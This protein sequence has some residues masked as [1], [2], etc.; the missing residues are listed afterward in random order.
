MRWLSLHAEMAALAHLP[1][2][3]CRDA[4]ASAVSLMPVTAA[5]RP[6][7]SFPL[8]AILP[9]YPCAR[10]HLAILIPKQPTSSSSHSPFPLFFHLRTEAKPEP[11]AAASS[12][13]SPSFAPAKPNRL[14]PGRLHLPA[15]MLEQLLALSELLPAGNR[16]SRGRQSL[17]R[18]PCSLSA[19]LRSSAAGPAW[20]P[21]RMLPIACWC[22]RCPLSAAS[23][24]HI[25]LLQ[26][27]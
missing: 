10:S 13:Q 7:S 26:K 14:N 15:C 8:L 5:R 18:P 25:E 19:R 24:L 4:F 6:R 11:G 9:L 17:P 22:C 20:E 21:M 27:S 12:T 16:G 23:F 2:R 1:A 3:P